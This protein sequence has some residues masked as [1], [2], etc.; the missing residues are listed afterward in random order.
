MDGK[1]RRLAA[2]CASM[3][4]CA[5]IAF[6]FTFYT[7]QPAYATAH[8]HPVVVSM[9]DSYSSGEGNE[10]FYGQEDSNKYK[11]ARR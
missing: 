3:A 1:Q 7:P 4:V 11:N 6:T 8:G 9:G 5:V 10:P 2:L